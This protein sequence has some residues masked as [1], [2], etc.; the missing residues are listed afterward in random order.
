MREGRR[1]DGTM[2]DSFMPWRSFQTMSDMELAA[3]W[4]YLRSVPPK[5]SG[6]K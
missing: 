5:A 4:L 3:L 6:N 2:L 1:P